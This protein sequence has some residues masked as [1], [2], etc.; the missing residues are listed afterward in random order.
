MCT[1]PVFKSLKTHLQGSCS[2]RSSC[3]RQ[4][5]GHNLEGLL[6]AASLRCHGIHSRLYNGCC[7]VGRPCAPS[8]M[9]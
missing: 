9:R 4:H 7:C 2:L 1:T 8:S 5:A 6:A 3:W